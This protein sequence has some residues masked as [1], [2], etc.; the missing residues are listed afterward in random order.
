M[1]SDS[2]AIDGSTVEPKQLHFLKSDTVFN[3]FLEN[4]G[5]FGKRYHFGQKYRFFL[6]HDY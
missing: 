6:K 1:Y 3:L 2:D 5:S 4:Y